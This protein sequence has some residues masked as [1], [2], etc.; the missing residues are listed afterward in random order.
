MNKFSLYIKES[1]DELRNNMT[2][3]TWANL[4]QTTGVVL[5]GVTVLALLIFLMDTTSNT[6]THFIYGMRK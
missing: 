2:W 4:Q 3:P 1:F 5:V 6:V